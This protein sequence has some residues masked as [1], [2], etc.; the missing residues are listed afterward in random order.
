MLCVGGT[1]VGLSPAV[2]NRLLGKV[3]RNDNRIMVRP[4]WR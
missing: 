2:S 3:K 4:M 1:G